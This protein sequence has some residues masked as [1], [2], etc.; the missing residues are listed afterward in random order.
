MHL[1]TGR[2]IPHAPSSAS[3]GQHLSP[4]LSAHHYRH[5]R[6]SQ[7]TQQRSYMNETTDNGNGDGDGDGRH[8]RGG[9]AETLAAELLLAGNQGGKASFIGKV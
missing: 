1:S 3:G 8:P 2:A 9:G 6:H 5:R 7:S 4:S